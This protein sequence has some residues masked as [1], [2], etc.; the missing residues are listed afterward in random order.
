[1]M[2]PSA[3]YGAADSSADQSQGMLTPQRRAAHVA[4]CSVIT[5]AALPLASHRTS[6]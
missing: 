4:G 5:D 3:G 1:M 2:V 6:K